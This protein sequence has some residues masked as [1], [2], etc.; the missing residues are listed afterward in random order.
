MVGSLHGPG[1]IIL[2]IITPQVYTS[3]LHSKCVTHVPLC[4]PRHVLCARRYHS[5][6]QYLEYCHARW[7]RN[8]WLPWKPNESTANR[9]SEV[10]QRW[11]LA[12]GIFIHKY[13]QPGYQRKPAISSRSDVAVIIARVTMRTRLSIVEWLLYFHHFRFEIFFVG[14][15]VAWWRLLRC[16]LVFDHR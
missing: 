8:V 5:Q 6:L 15:Q 12:V 13:M 3:R 16:A 4:A 7:T 10:T 2:V 11:C 9:P 1:V 14:E